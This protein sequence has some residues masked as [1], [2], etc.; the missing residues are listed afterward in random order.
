MSRRSH[1]RRGSRDRLSEWAALVGA[2]LPGE[3][4]AS[5]PADDEASRSAEADADRRS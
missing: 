1:D 5:S 2:E 4:E 3:S